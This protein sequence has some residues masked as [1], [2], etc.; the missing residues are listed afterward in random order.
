MIVVVTT[1]EASRIFSRFY[2]C[3]AMK[4]H[5]DPA[6]INRAF[7]R[8]RVFIGGRER[9]VNYFFR[10][11][12][13]PSVDVMFTVDVTTPRHREFCVPFMKSPTCGVCD[14]TVNTYRYVKFTKAHRWILHQ[15]FSN[16]IRQLCKILFLHIAYTFSHSYKINNYYDEKVRSN[17][18]QLSLICYFNKFYTI[19]ISI[20]FFC[21]IVILIMIL[22]RKL[23]RYTF[24]AQLLKNV[25]RSHKN[26]LNN[27]YKFTQT[28]TY[29]RK[30][31]SCILPFYIFNFVLIS[32]SR[33]KYFIRSTI[34]MLIL[35]VISIST[36]PAL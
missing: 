15:S 28:L 14:V 18:K 22:F 31:T 2:M 12:E 8:S 19:N 10:R 30:R 13:R 9:A 3:N 4:T 25:I 35:F 17:L 36:R 1:S 24:M 21:K 27:I 32:P 6:G 7:V 20:I 11:Y 5:A 33:I 34:L 16:F 23:Y 26:F 29:M